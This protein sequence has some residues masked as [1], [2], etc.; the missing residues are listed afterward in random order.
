MGQLDGKV[1]VI[2]GAATGIGAASARRFVAEGAA[3]AILDLN[4]AD[5]EALVAELAAAGGTARFF[6]CDVADLAAVEAAV[7]QAAGELGGIDIVFAN[8]AVGTVVVGGTVESIEPER[9]DMAFDVNV[10][11]VYGLCRAALP[12]LRQRGG[13]SIVITSSSSAIIGVPGPRATHAYAAAK[14]AVISLVRA[15]A[16]TY[17]PEGIRVNG[18]APGFVRTRLTQD[19]IDQPDRLAQALANIPLRRF[20][21]PEELANCALFLA[22]DAASFVTGTVLVADGGQTVV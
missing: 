12:H 22:S 13:G 7:D 16:A 8:A 15:M 1:A 5:G 14:G 17:G 2:S 11:G 4:A 3:V 19:I 21:E 9:W 10:R 18:L 20:A 6:S